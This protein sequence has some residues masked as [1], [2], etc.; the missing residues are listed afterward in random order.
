MFTPALIRAALDGQPAS[1]RE[2]VDVLSPVVHSRV[3]RTLSRR[4]PSAR[5]PRQEVE[6]LTQEV[7][8][9][10]FAQEGRLLRTWDPER[11]LSLQNFVGLIAQREANAIVRSG[12]RS[13]WKDDPLEPQ[14]LEEVGEPVPDVG[15]EVAS[16]QELGIVLERLQAGLSPLGYQMFLRLVVQQETV[17]EVAAAENMSLA[18][19]Y[20]WQSRLARRIRAL[21]SELSMETGG[22]VGEGAR[23]NLAR[24]EGKTS[25]M[26]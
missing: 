12:R 11:G 26:R 25:G 8:A 2:L 22:A 23:S 14:D 3:A 10:L 21:W 17:Q 7:F 19:V 16:R 24:R 20:A 15:P 9:R 1:V 18:A 4:G 5:D 6:D 13:P